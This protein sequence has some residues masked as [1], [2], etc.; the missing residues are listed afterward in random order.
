MPLH[1]KYYQQ[2]YGFT[3]L[4]IKS[5]CL[6][7]NLTDFYGSKSEMFLKIWRHNIVSSGKILLS[8]YFIPRQTNHSWLVTFSD[9]N[10]KLL[11][12]GAASMI[13]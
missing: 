12:L 5:I 8:T 13:L 6:V 1:L 11:C 10:I 2:A 9:W 4:G 7:F 3:V